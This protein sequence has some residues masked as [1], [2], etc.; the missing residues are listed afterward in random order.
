MRRR[1][2]VLSSVVAAIGL[3]V[4]VAVALMVSLDGDSPTARQTSPVAASDRYRGG[5]PP[6]GI[7]LSDFSLRNYDGRLIRSGDLLGRVTLLTFLDSQCTDS[8]PVIAWTVARTID[9]LTSAE[10]RDVRAVA[11]STDPTEDTERSV[12]RFLA[13]NRALG[14]LLYVGGGQPETELRAV[15]DR[16]HVLSS[17]ESGADTL[18]SA[19]VRIYDRHGAWVTTLHAGAD[20]TEA[21]LAHDIRVALTSDRD[22]G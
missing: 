5:E 10:R 12:R 15:W 4:A 21:S 2:A 16:F 18:H 17:L 6:P 1:L 22:T 13:G 8:C 11:I 14:R 19:P 7:T 3:G 9:S 20:L